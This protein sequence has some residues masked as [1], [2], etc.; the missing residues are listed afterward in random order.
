MSRT[1][2]NV[3]LIITVMLSFLPAGVLQELYGKQHLTVESLFAKAEF[4]VIG[5]IAKVSRIEVDANDD[6]ILELT[7]HFDE[8]LKGTAVGQQKLS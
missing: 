8:F 6:E 4:V 7:P 5:T 2:N 1:K 3:Y